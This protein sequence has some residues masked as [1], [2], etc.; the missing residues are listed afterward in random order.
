MKDKANREITVKFLFNHLKDNYN[1]WEE[2]TD[3]QL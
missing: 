2:E 3:E 1:Y